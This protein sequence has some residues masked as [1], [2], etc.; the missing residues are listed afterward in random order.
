M[1]IY[2]PA[3]CGK[4]LTSLLIAREIVRGNDM[5]HTWRPPAPCAKSRAEVSSQPAVLQMRLVG[6]QHLFAP[7]N[8]L[9]KTLAAKHPTCVAKMAA[10][11]RASTIREDCVSR[12]CL[13]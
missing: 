10:K 1:A 7:Y 5:L 12:H 2:G 11:Y 8:F 3:G 6:V 9:L 4:S 13:P